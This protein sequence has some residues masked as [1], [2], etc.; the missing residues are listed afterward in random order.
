M[1]GA[2]H[3]LV[4]ETGWDPASADLLIG[5]SAGAVV[6]ALIAGGARPWDILV[7]ERSDFFQSL[8]YATAFRPE[9]T[10]GSFGPG[11]MPLA[12]R[13][14]RGGPGRAIKLMAGLLPGGFVST[15][16]IAR[17]IEEQAPSGWPRGLWIVATDHLTG[18][19]TVFGRDGEAP[20]QLPVAVAASCAVPG[21]YRPV[22]VGGRPYVDGG[23]QSGAN[24]DLAAEARLDLVICAN[25]L[26]SPVGSV[27]SLAAPVRAALHRQLEVQMRA[28]E[29]AGAALVVLEPAGESVHLIGLNWMS[30]SRGA[31]I[32]QAASEEVRRHLRQPAVQRL[33]GPLANPRSAA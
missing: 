3:G 18:E 31:A 15:A 14:L 23:V 4:G 19:R 5:T 29:R 25:P 12:R 11:S 9:L 33:L 22:R 26:S 8:M 17:M 28:V 2:L 7:P 1:M 27:R 16:P 32:G 13:G 30:R 20:A 6:A 10:L 21:F 24:L